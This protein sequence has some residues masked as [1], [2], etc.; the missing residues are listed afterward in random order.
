MSDGHHSLRISIRKELRLLDTLK[1]R[2]PDTV[3]RYIPEE[4]DVD[5]ELRLLHELTN[6]QIRRANLPISDPLLRRP[7]VDFNHVLNGEFTERQP[8]C[9]LEQYQAVTVTGSHDDPD[10]VV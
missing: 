5:I 8:P 6:A 9:Q 4:P 10:P 2:I 1:P 3:L 7:E